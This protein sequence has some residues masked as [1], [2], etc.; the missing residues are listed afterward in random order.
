M[1]LQYD[2][3]NDLL[4]KQ[5]GD[6]WALGLTILQFYGVDLGMKTRAENSY[7]ALT[8]QLIKK[9]FEDFNSLNAKLGEHKPYGALIGVQSVKRLQNLLNTDILSQLKK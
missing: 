8:M 9:S 7:A 1:A 6:N 2:D 4:S 3:G 5:R